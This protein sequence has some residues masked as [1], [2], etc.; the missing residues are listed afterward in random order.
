MTPTDETTVGAEA[1]DRGATS[2]FLAA[3]EEGV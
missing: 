2:A 3:H 1:D